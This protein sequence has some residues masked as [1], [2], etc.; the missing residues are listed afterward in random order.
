MGKLFSQ[1]SPVIR[2]LWKMADLIVLNL[3]WIVCCIPVVTIGPATTAMY[4]VARRIAKGEWPAILKTFFGEFRANFRQ[5]L[6][7][8][9]CLLIP[10]G[11][12]VIYLVL[13]VT[14]ALDRLELIKYFAYLAT[15]IVGG[16]C[17]YTYPLLARFDNTLGNTL[18]NAILLPLANPILA[19]AATILNLLPV[20]I[21]LLDL[22]LFV[23][24]SFFWLAIG[25]SLTALANTRLLGL[26]FDRFAPQA[27]AEED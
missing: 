4:C 23:T 7:A 17:T 19:L 6:L 14:G 18:R 5:S 3:V 21:M 27:P 20:I 24:V 13:S 25:F 1:D 10:A 2:F 15:G 16:I 26:V 8:F 12:A 22:Q 9:L 11:L